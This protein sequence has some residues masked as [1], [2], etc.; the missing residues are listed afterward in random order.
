MRALY[1][2][3]QQQL[4]LATGLPVQVGMGDTPI[5]ERAYWTLEAQGQEAGLSFTGLTYRIVATLHNPLAPEKDEIRER[6][7]LMAQAERYLMRS[8]VRESAPALDAQVEGFDGQSLTVRFEVD[9]S[10]PVV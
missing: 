6:L 3:F 2:W 5:G 7:R 8:E 9:W 10:A 1:D 4:Y